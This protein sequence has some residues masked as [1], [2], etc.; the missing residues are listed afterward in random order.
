MKGRA[1]QL[2][3]NREL[4]WLE[5]N[6]RVLEEAQDAGNPLLER[7]R[8]FCIFN[9]NLDE[10]FMVR[11]ASLLRKVREGDNESD[12]SGLTP[13][14][15]LEQI[16]SRV[17]ELQNAACALYLETL[18]PALA[19]E[20][21]RILA[22][23]ELTAAQQKYVDDYFDR[24]ISPVLTPIA[25][26][27]ERPFPRLV[28]LAFNLGA[29]LASER[30]PEAGP[31][32]A[33]VQVPG[34]LPGLCRLPDTGA[35]ELCWLNDVIRRR[36]FT[37]FP[38]YRVTEAAGFRL[39]RDSEVEFDD[40]GQLDYVGMLESE[41]KNRRKARPISVEYEAQM[42]PALLASLR[43]GLGV[44]ESSIFPVRGPLDA[45]PLL[46]V[47]D[48]PGFDRLRYKPQ[49]PL[50]PA[51][52]EP[53]RTI[54]DLIRD[55]DIL[56][57]H[58]FDS[59]DPVVEFVRNAAEDPDVLAVKQ[60]LYRTGGRGSQILNA[61]LQAAEAGK[62]VSVLIELTARF[63]EERNI[64]WARDLE[65][66]GAHVIY[67]IEA[68]K[69]HAK[70]SLVVRREADGIRRYV[71][72]G[73]GNYN[74]RTARL[75]TDF[76][77]LTAADDFGRDASG[78]FNTITGCSELPVFS[79]LIMAPAGMRDRIL[80]LIRREADWAR[81]GQKS[82]ILAKMNSLVDPLIIKELCAASEVGV[83]I[84]L[85]VRGICC[86]RPGVPGLSEKIRVVSVVDRYLEHSRAL[87]LRNGGNTEVYL[88]SA[89][90]MP[91]NLDRRIE[92]M[93]P[94]LQKSPQ[95]R[96]IEALEAQFA[97]NQKARALKPDGTYERVSA[98]RQEPLRAQEHLYAR[99]LEE[100]ERL[101]PITPV[102]FVPIEGKK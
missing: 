70:I 16:F 43:Q 19:N 22:L 6:R 89:D 91:R 79:R 44:N 66:A 8:F 88:S 1:Q 51:V 39:A 20:K 99:A 101:R 55:G 49:P 52:F 62:E 11:V 34:R 93:F 33:V 84:Q 102:R 71:H 35:L 75:Y 74:E 95:R 25:I 53:E 87:V 46:S 100:K 58:P 68:L 97:D 41:L 83:P 10:F 17:R 5:F 13:Y 32:L 82:G 40:E 24:E 29:L 4:S 27:Q 54:F 81:S 14:L 96:V 60:T 3:L 80:A 64:S 18:L 36:L 37:L 76:S 12:P 38:G 45:R 23:E 50:L 61:L 73:T 28:G 21:I 92:L 47:V 90:W 63:D 2:Y 77:L 65:D 56:L 30:N 7:V 31:I 98:G 94:V 67:G 86:L 26:G 59:F 9:S 85:N 72:L 78:F 57:H 48:M 42:S 15:Q 69:V